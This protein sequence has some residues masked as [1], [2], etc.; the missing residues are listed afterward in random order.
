MT[1]RERFV[2]LTGLLLI[3]G[4]VV[5][6]LITDFREGAT[7]WHLITEGSIGALALIGVL[8][9]AGSTLA[10]KKALSKEQSLSSSLKLEAEGWRNRSRKYLEG[11]SK[12][13]D[14]QLSNWKLTSAEKEVAFLLLKG[15]SLKEI[16]T[17]RET[18]E[19]T[20]RV[21]SMAI[22]SKAGLAGRAEL[23]AFFLED[24]LP[25]DPREEEAG[26]EERR[27]SVP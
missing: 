24:L 17:I 1:H 12:S 6:D 7:I 11:L 16:A 22:Y 20:S 14:E 18:A 25:P 10:L 21:Q 15:M 19:K 8:Y 5:A 3:A 13:I 27:S 4:T 26:T 2:L 23:S 9:L